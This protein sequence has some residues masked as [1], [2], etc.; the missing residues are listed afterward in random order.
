MRRRLT[1]K[2]RGNLYKVFIAPRDGGKFYSLAK[3]Q[4]SGFPKD[5]NHDGRKQRVTKKAKGVETAKDEK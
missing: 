5:S 4:A 2:Q 1:G 3:A